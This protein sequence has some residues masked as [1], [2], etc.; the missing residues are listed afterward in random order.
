MATPNRRNSS[1]I[2]TVQHEVLGPV[3]ILG[4]PFRLSR[5]EV[6]LRAAPLLGRHT[7]EV[8]R[9]DL[10]LSDAELRGLHAAGVVETKES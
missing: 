5:S 7:D 2:E 9:G 3:P 6:E 1:C 10:G 4:S 8:L